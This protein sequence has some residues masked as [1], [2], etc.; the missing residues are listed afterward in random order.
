MWFIF[1]TAAL[2]IY[3]W[4]LKTVVFLHW[5]LICAVPFRLHFVVLFQSNLDVQQNEF[6]LDRILGEISMHKLV[7]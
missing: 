4:Q 5:C 7:R 1:S 6:V 2:I 3:L